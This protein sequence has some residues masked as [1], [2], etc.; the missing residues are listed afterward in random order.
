MRTLCSRGKEDLLREDIVFTR[1]RRLAP[2]GQVS[3]LL[4]CCKQLHL[5]NFTVCNIT[6][7]ETTTET[8]QVALV[9][10]EQMSMPL[11][12]LMSSLRAGQVFI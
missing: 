1:E 8:L 4:Q 6:G 9:S 3:R 11:E 7:V 5:T 10:I 2:R 12:V